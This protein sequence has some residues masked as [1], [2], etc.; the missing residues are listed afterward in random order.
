MFRKIIISLLLASLPLLQGCLAYTGGYC[1]GG[2][3]KKYSVPAAKK[4]PVSYSVEFTQSGDSDKPTFGKSGE[5][6]R[7]QVGLALEKTGLFS[8][9]THSPQ[10]GGGNY[11]IAFRFWR[12]GTDT[13]DAVGAGMIGGSALWLI[14]FGV[15]LTL[16]ASANISLR[17]KPVVG[18][19][20]AENSKVIYWLGF[21]PFF[22]SGLVV[23]DNMDDYVLVSIVNDAAE[24]H[25]R[26]F[27]VQQNGGN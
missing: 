9:V 3:V 26:N 27:V 10:A 8:S 15:E 21:L 17:G 1:E 18:L 2:K 4:F 23:V 5:D 16:D 25:Y 6:F 22:I 14:P 12:S 20:E 7:E 11:H 24:Y 19:A 13:R